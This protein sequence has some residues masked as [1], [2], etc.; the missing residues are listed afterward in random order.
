[1]V[2][3]KKKLRMSEYIHVAVTEKVLWEMLWQTPQ[4]R[5]VV[6]HTVGV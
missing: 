4:K 1:M 3:P 6:S 2:C 5:M